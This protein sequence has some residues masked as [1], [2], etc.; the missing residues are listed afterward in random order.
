MISLMAVIAWAIVTAL[1]SVFGYVDK[2]IV[3]VLL[4]LFFPV[5]GSTRHVVER[6]SFFR[7]QLTKVLIVCLS[8]SAGIT[9]LRFG[10]PMNI[11]SIGLAWL[12]TYQLFVYL[13]SLSLFE[14]VVGRAPADVAF[15]YGSGRVF[16]R[17]LHIFWIV[18]LIVVPVMLRRELLGFTST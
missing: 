4:I 13:V 15:D 12:P 8:I 2:P 3:S 16:D 9:V 18:A 11:A 17:S 7:P 5:L 14:R 10:G 6:G 1:C